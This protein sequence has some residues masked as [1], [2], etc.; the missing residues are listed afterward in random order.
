MSKLLIDP[1]GDD[2]VLFCSF[3]TMKEK[4]LVV[5]VVDSYIQVARGHAGSTAERRRL[6]SSLAMMELGMPRPE[7]LGIRDDD[8][9]WK[10]L[11]TWLNETTHCQGF[12][13]VIYPAYEQGGHPHHNQVALCVQ[14]VFNGPEKKTQY[15]TYTRGHG[16][17]RVSMIPGVGEKPFT[18]V[19]VEVIPTPD[20]I[21]RKHR[22]L[23]CYQSQMEVPDCASWFMGDLREYVL[24]PAQSEGRGVDVGGVR[25]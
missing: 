19:A 18:N 14:E 17:S 4:P 15:L 25:L 20:M 10:A 23:A 2:G 3:L 6:E 8:P 7:F 21:A 1:H 13:E 22:A 5:V 9:D 16:R 24:P 11:R 12:E